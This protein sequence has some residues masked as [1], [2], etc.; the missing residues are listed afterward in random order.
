VD[1]LETLRQEHEVVLRVARAAQ[2]ILD[3]AEADGELDIARTA[4]L[5]D[6]LRYFTNACHTPKE[7]DLLFTALHRHGLAWDEPPL[8]EL[9]GQH[10]ELRAAL[11]SASDRLLLATEDVPGSLEPLIHDLRGAVDLLCV[12]VSLEE[13][14]LFPVAADLLHRRDL[15]SLVAEFADIACD[16]R[17]EG[18]H[19]YYAGVARDL[20]GAGV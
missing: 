14:V 3:A 6:F 18:V 7:E 5:L 10:A 2:R 16:E 13:D 15:E 9:V 8:R 19:D 1:A 11:D 17:Q 12:H 4:E 20:A